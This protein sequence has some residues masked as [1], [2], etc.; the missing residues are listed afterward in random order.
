MRNLNVL[1]TGFD[2]FGGETENPSWQVAQALD[3]QRIGEH[4]VV[5]ECLPTSFRKALGHLLKAIKTHRPALVLC[6]GQAGGRTR[7]SLERVAINLIDARIADNEGWQPIDMPVLDGGPAAYF[8]TLPIKAMLG[9][10]HEAQ[11]PAHMSHSAG[12]FVCNQVFYGLMHHLAKSDTPAG[13]MHIPYSS[14]QTAD[15][16]R[17]APSMSLADMEQGVRVALACALDPT[18]TAPELSGGSEH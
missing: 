8:S 10:L 17:D 5:A 16:G 9:A 15:S 7:L 2:A 14:Q 12:T 18:R 6:L 11:L 3:G 1:L 4:Q 13:F